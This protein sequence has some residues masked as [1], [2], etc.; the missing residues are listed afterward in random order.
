MA[1][2]LQKYIIFKTV[3]F[4][5]FCSSEKKNKQGAWLNKNMKHALVEKSSKLKSIKIHWLKKP[6][7]RWMRRERGRFR[8]R[9]IIG[10]ID[11]YGKR[12]WKALDLVREGEVKVFFYSLI[13]NWFRPR[14]KQ[15]DPV[16]RE[17]ERAKF[18]F[19]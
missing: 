16:K 11:L 5:V 8:E 1:V 10:T 15:E 13:A 12:H 6:S 9:D 18:T 14:N 17:R 7:T 19:S 4:F 2:K 3:T